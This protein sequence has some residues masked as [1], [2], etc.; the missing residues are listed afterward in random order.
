MPVIVYEVEIKHILG[1]SENSSALRYPEVWQPIELIKAVGGRVL[2]DSPFVV[3]G[4][5]GISRK[6]STIYPSP[7]LEFTTKSR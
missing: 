4:F 7:V 5:E 1:K 6:Q 3:N 2:R